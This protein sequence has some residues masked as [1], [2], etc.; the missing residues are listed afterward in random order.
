MSM[1]YADDDPICEA[2]CPAGNPSQTDST[3]CI[4]EP[5]RQA[6]ERQHQQRQNHGGCAFW[7]MS[8][9]IM[10]MISVENEFHLSPHVEGGEARGNKQH[11]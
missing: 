4:H 2:M 3:G 6:E 5:N 7:R 1:L 8:G 10:A 11:P 9:G